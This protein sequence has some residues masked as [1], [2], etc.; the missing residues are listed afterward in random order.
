MTQFVYF[1][2]Q[3]PD[4][5]R[6]LQ[7]SITSVQKNFSGDA[8]I[9]VIGEKPHW[10]T[11]HHIPMTQ[12]RGIHDAHARMPFRDTQHKIMAA[13]SH[14]EIDEE[15][16]WIM[17]DC[18]MMKP[19]TIEEIM[20]PRFDPWYRI[21]MKSV[22]HQL[23]RMTF[24]ALQR[25]GKTNMQYSTHLP[26][27]FEKSKLNEMFGI[28][29]FP[30]QLL[31]FENLYGNHYNN[32]DK[33]LPYGANWNGVQHVQFLTRLL[34]PATRS[35]LDQID[36]HFLNYQSKCWNASMRLWLENRFMQ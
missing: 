11:G 25:N 23:I 9:T 19:T 20:I 6:E 8:K 7:I 36:C 27:A 13:A 28:Y 35:Q 5:G 22:W 10:Y 31:L 12:F 2:V 18:F 30:K 24:I 4:N 14:P 26:H 3:A 32:P 15:F 16:V 33:S 34:R 17:D 1:Y 29:D 21:N